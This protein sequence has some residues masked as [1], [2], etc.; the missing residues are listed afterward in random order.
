MSYND[1]IVVGAII[2]VLI[3]VL[4]LWWYDYCEK[5]EERELNELVKRK[6]EFD[7]SNEKR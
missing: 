3:L 1:I 6:D 7:R 4:A 2:I 5:L